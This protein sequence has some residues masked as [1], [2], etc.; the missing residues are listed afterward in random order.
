VSRINVRPYLPTDR[1]SVLPLYEHYWGAGESASVARHWDWLIDRPEGAPGPTPLAY[2]LEREGRLAGVAAGFRNSLYVHGQ[3]FPLFWIV[4]YLVEPGGPGTISGLRLVVGFERFRYDQLWAGFALPITAPLWRRATGREGVHVLSGF[5]LMVRP[6]SPA[7]LARRW[8]S[9]GAVDRLRIGLAAPLLRLWE[10]V[11]R[12]RAGP[13][14]PGITIQPTDRFD[15]RFDRFF[16]RVMPDYQLITHRDTAYLDW[17][18]R[19]NQVRHYRI[20]TAEDGEGSLRGYVIYAVDT[21]ASGR[22]TGRI[23]DLLTARTDVRVRR[24]LVERAVEELEK[25]GCEAVRIRDP[26]LPDVRRELGRAG[27]FRHA[28]GAATLF[29]YDRAD[30]DIPR[31]L[32]R[33]PS[34]WYLTFDRSYELGDL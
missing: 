14:M 13:G 12:W 7:Y 2:V 10:G 23:S 9:G 5:G 26:G 6:L 28:Q 27:F 20:L 32:V 31:D 8:D 11:V 1:E 16:T 33:E 25:E 19:D 15:A 17:R 29:L 3:A 30:P 4:D 18:F 22:I 34:N 21:E 24:C